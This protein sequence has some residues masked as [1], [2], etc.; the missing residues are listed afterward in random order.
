MGK[1]KKIVI[2]WA[3]TDLAFVKLIEKL[4]RENGRQYKFIR[5]NHHQ[6]WFTEKRSILLNGIHLLKLFLLSI[7]VAANNSVL[8]FGTNSC[9]LL[10]PFSFLFHSVRLVYNEIPS[11]RQPKWV[12][13]IDKLILRS[14]GDIYVSS[15]ERSRYI[16]ERFRLNRKPGVVLNTSIASWSK[17]NINNRVDGLVYAGSITKKRFNSK[18]IKSIKD[19]GIPVYLYGTFHNPIQREIDDFAEFCGHVAQD[20]VLGAV[21]KFKYSL[22][23]Y[24]RDEINYDLCAPIKIYEYIAAGCIILSVEDNQ[25]LE[26]Y[27]K[28]YPNLFKKLAEFRLDEPV[29]F[30]EWELEREE[31]LNHALNNNIEFAKSF[32]EK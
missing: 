28:N 4:S 29:N 10:G 5:W 1:R 6:S 3:T 19:L 15:E 25:G 22:I 9:R 26:Y 14:V 17:V 20:E 31:F 16:R 30:L 18:T 8:I 2:Y 7:W 24:Y 21:S 11:E 12:N 13:L 23:S 27:F 32:F